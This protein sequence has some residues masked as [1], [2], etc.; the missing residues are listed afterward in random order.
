MEP[1]DSMR[2]VPM[3]HC[4][5]HTVGSICCPNHPGPWHRP[6]HV[7][8]SVSVAYLL[9]RL[10][11]PCDELLSLLGPLEGVQGADATIDR[12]FRG[13]EGWTVDL[14]VR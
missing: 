3:I 14:L 13:G 6:R 11:C 1:D 2:H 10:A 8:G 7:C 5:H 12:G 9:D 4:M